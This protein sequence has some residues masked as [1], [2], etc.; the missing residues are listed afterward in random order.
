M[1]NHLRRS[2]LACLVILLSVPC[3]AMGADSGPLANDFELALGAFFLSANTQLRLDGQNTL[4]GTDVNW[5]HDLGLEDKDRF[6]VDGFWRFA[7]RHKVRVMYYENNRSGTRSLA[8]D[9]QFGDTT[10]PVNARVDA[11]LDTRVIELAYEYAFLK[12]DTVELSGS[13]GIHDVKL[14]AGLSGSISAGSGG[15]SAQANK[16]ASTE[17]PFPV[18]GVHV[19]WHMGHN[20]F[21]DGLGQFFFAKIDNIDGRLTDYKVAINWYSRSHIGVGI[22]YNDFVTT[23]DVDKRNFSGRLRLQNGGPLVFVTA[24]F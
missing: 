22:G 16:E 11:E 8:R 24:S 20:F 23:V 10:F 19:L 4:T 21:L 3:L 6:R 9:I 5:E 15:L 1:P 12:K 2:L 13:F 17:G 7:K 14:S 18:V